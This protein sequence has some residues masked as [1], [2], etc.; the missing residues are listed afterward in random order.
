MVV[1]RIADGL[2]LE[3]LTI[4]RLERLR[5]RDLELHRRIRGLPRHDRLGPNLTLSIAGG[6]GLCLSKLSTMTLSEPLTTGALL[7]RLVHTLGIDR[8]ELLPKLV[9]Q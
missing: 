6:S 5:I 4:R 3:M 1:R 2:L 8:L 7:H 9:N